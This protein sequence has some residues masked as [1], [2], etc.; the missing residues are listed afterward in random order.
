MSLLTVTGLQ[1]WFDVPGGR[2]VHAVRDVDLELG[3]GQ[4]LGLVGESGSGK[5]TT[6]LALMGLLPPSASVEGEIRVDGTDILSGGERSMRPHRWTDL[7]M[8]FQGAMNAFN[9]VLTVGRQ[10]IE[11]MTFHRTRRPREARDRAIELL[12]MVG[13]S[14]EIADR[15]P[16]QLSG[17]MRQRAA[18]AMALACEPK[19][20]LADEPTTALDVMAQAQVL[21][22]LG[23]LSE[24]LDLALVLVTHDLAMVSQICDRTAVMYAGEVVENGPAE[25]LYRSARHPYTRLLFAATPDPYDDRPVTSISGSPPRLDRVVVGCPFHPRCDSTLEICPHVHP[26]LLEVLP[27]HRAACHLNTVGNQT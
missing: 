16:H 15:Y 6:I 12:D 7:A 20:L 9:P 21:Q 24:D 1:V 8:V 13:L 22:L 17:G 5:T 27:G 18:I 14:R 2:Q 10:I 26:P 11:P 3:P 25:G 23:R 19:I 4:R